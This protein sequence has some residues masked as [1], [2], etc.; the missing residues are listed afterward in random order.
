MKKQQ[1]ER[2]YNFS[3]AVL[4]QKCDNVNHSITRD[5]TEFT[6]RGFLV[7]DNTAFA[8]LRDDFDAMPSDVELEGIVSDITEQKDAA[9]EA[10]R[11]AVR[12]F[13]TAAQNK[14]GDDKAKYRTY[15]FDDMSNM[16]DADLVRL[17]KRVSRIA[18][19]QQPDLA[20]G[21]NA[22]KIAALD[23]L[24]KAL[25][26]LIDLKEDGTNQRD[27]FTEDRIE[28]GNAL[29]AVLVKV[30]NT[31]KNIW[32]ATDEAKYN[33]YVIYNT[34]SGGPEPPPVP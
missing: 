24:N 26:D 13:R 10:L 17:G 8:T 3:D 28:A 33:D 22:A 27:I 34:P 29:Y 21:I 12:E 9:A 25:D 32:E 16:P 2:A 6:D 14:W 30:C 5:Q 31:G 18:S 11:V 20:P 15:G 7:A 19:I 23:V 4:I 1:V